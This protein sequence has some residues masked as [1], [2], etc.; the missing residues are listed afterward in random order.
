MTLSE[1]VPPHAY[2]RRW[3]NPDSTW[4]MILQQRQ[5][6]VLLTA[7]SGVLANLQVA[8]TAAD[9]IPKD[10][11]LEAAAAGGSQ[12]MCQWFLD[13][14]DMRCSIS[15]PAAVEAAAA[16]GHLNLVRWLLQLRDILGVVIPSDRL[17]RYA[18]R[19]AA[20]AGQRAVCEGLLADGVQCSEAALAAALQKGHGALA[21]RLLELQPPPTGQSGNV[22]TYVLGKAATGADLPLLQRVCRFYLGSRPLVGVKG[23]TQIL[24]GAVM[25]PTSDW[26]DKVAW[27]EQQG[28]SMTLEEAERAK[29]TQH[30]MNYL[31]LRTPQ[32]DAVERLQ[33]LRQRGLLVMEDYKRIYIE[34]AKASSLP[35]LRYIREHN[36]LGGEQA[37]SCDSMAAAAGKG[38]V[39]IMSELKKLGEKLTS[40]AAVRAARN[41]HLNALQWMAG[42]EAGLEGEAALLA[43]QPCLTYHAAW[44]GSRAV[45]RW[46]RERGCP[47][48]DRT[49]KY[50]AASGN[51]AL[52]EM[53]A[54]EGCPMQVRACEA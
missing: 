24:A 13:K 19:A 50:A 26:R 31:Y 29:F 20:G 51:T 14:G 54:A 18:F 9:C 39:E 6:L 10:G 40:E 41:G 33:L 28:L 7:R 27:L 30:L 47:W 49:F 16:A 38:D 8:F 37:F 45:M 53:L 34:A 23:K 17:G 52:L 3:G 4:D 42:P 22:P 2:L 43:A 48:A 35:V 12:E 5:R 36:L 11:V 21:E 15:Y 25:S 46:A 32:A 44:S 1:P